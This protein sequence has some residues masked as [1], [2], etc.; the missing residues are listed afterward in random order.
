MASTRPQ[1]RTLLRDEI[2]D[3]E[4]VSGTA[5]G[6]SLTTVV[7]SSRLTQ[8]N[9]YWKKQTVYIK[10]TTDTL[11]PQGEAR[12]ISSSTQSTATVTVE[13]PFSAAV[14]SGDTWGIAVFS[15]SRMNQA[16]ND[17]LQ[18]FSRWRPYKTTES[19]NVASGSRRF[20]P[21]SANNIRN[22]RKVEFFDNTT[23]EYVDYH[24]QWVWDD[25]LRQIEFS[26]WW[27][28]SKTLTL[29]IQ[30]NHPALTDESTQ[31]TVLPNEE[32]L[33]VRLAA[34]LLLMSMSEK[35]FRDDFG[36]LKPKSWR[37]GE[38]SMTYGD[39]K[40]EISSLHET[41]MKDIKEQVY[42][43]VFGASA[44]A[45]AVSSSYGMAVDT[46]SD[47]DGQTAPQIFWTLR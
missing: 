29:H 28:E 18:R 24:G 42:E 11:A 25:H 39:F 13:L 3:A 40:T 35:E 45:T 47:P 5:T 26:Y 7:D 41:V 44:G 1:L 9:D 33:I 17:A 34:V 37:R 19:M 22:V 43:P 23:Q 15:D 38:V 32:N 16:L 36:E 46:K 2:G 31:V 6:G 12:R 14:Q 30:K 8:V 21:T 20:A 27:T 10:T 4:R